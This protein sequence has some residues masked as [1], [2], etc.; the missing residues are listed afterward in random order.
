MPEIRRLRST[1]SGRRVCRRENVSRRFVSCA[2]LR[3]PWMAKS[4]GRRMFGATPVSPT[5][6]GGDVKRWRRISRLPMMIVRRLLKSCA[7]PPV[8]CPTASIFCAW[9]SVASAALA[10][11]GLGLELAGALAQALQIEIGRAREQRAKADRRR[12]AD[13]HEHDE[14]GAQRL[15]DRLAALEETE[16][17]GGIDIDP[18]PDV[19]HQGLAAVRADHRR[20]LSVP[21]GLRER[22]GLLRDR[23]PLL[24]DRLQGGE[25]R[26]LLRVVGGEGAQVLER[27]RHRFEAGVIRFEIDVFA[28]QEVAALA[29]L[30]VQK[31]A[32]K[33]AGDAAHFVGV[34][35]E[36]LGGAGADEQG[37][38]G[39]GRRGPRTQRQGP[40]A[41]PYAAPARIPGR[42]N[43]CTEE[44]LG[45]GGRGHS[46]PCKS[47]SAA[48]LGARPAGR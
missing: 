1:V 41:G 7:M 24:D 38:R 34:V 16:L 12:E 43:R 31:V 9:R 28:G 17:F 21:A 44:P 40:E 42:G 10:A 14:P 23:E 37:D 5:A 45:R 47:K 35:D 4:S 30:G 2:A 19:V 46:R 22:H 25:A 26:Q 13:E 27:H 48:I 6:C 20:R 33:I 3:A 8:S 18:G 29:G 36:A 11:L 39:R 15:A 32:E